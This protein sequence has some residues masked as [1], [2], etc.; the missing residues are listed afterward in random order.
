M[1]GQ[2]RGAEDFSECIKKFELVLTLQGMSSDFEKVFLT[3]K[4]LQ[5]STAC[6]IKKRAT[7]KL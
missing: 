7:T 6:W 5:F 1:I 3:K 2:F 4:H